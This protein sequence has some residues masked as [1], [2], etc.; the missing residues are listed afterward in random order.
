MKKYTAYF[1]LSAPM[2]F[3]ARTELEAKHIADCLSTGKEGIRLCDEQGKEIARKKR[4]MSF[5]GE[6]FLWTL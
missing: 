4:M 3:E 2:T 6:L 5:S 1:A